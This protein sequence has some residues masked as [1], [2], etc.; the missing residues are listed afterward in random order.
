M[1]IIQDNELI[2]INNVDFLYKL[3]AKETQKEFETNFFKKY[4]G[5]FALILIFVLLVV[6]VVL[7]QNGMFE[8]LAG[9][10]Q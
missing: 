4:Q 7:W 3:K 5:L 6:V 8:E 1:P 9:L 2:D 10:L